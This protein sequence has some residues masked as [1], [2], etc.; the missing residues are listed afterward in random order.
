MEQTFLLC[1]QNLGFQIGTHLRFHLV[2]LE[3]LLPYQQPLD[4]PFL[5]EGFRQFVG[6]VQQLQTDYRWPEG[7][8]HLLRRHDQREIVMLV[9]RW[10][11]CGL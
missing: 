10:R 3:G 11:S 1:H 8:L 9:I 6:T 7:R 2:T 5:P 4:G